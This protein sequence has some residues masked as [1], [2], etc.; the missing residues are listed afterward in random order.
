MAKNLVGKNKRVRLEP[1][2][3]DVADEFSLV[4]RG[5]T[6]LIDNQ[7]KQRVAA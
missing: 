4:V 5:F 6:N 3:A 2:N 1:D 7:P